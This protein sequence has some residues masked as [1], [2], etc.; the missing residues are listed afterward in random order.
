MTNVPG[1]K[2]YFY[3]T[4]TL[5]FSFYMSKSFRSVADRFDM[6]KSSLHL[7]VT[8]VADALF[9]LVAQEIAFPTDITVL[10]AVTRTFEKFLGVI[11]CV[12]GTY[13]LMI[14][15]SGP[16]R[17]P[18]ICRKGFP[19]LHAQIVCDNNLR[20][21]DITTGH[22]GH[23]TPGWSEIVAYISICRTFLLAS[24]CSA[25]QHIRWNVSSWPPTKITG[26]WQL[27]RRSTML[28]TRLHLVALRGELVFSKE[29]FVD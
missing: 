27:N 13:I 11:R 5:L 17:D 3:F 18:Y 7:C 25:I 14:G 28:C 6:S 20:I 19:A 8:N 26:I 1:N 10:H 16:Q 15:K 24:T 2:I 23:M 9:R 22:P 12:D 21:L 29:N 4:A